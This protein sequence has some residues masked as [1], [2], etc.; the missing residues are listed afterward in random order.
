[1]TEA[2]LDPRERSSIIRDSLGVGVAT[3]AYG[4]GFGAVSVAAGLSVAQTCALSLLVFT[5]ASQFALVGVIATGG[6]P[7]SGALSAM[8][9]GT[10][11]TLYGLRLAP[12]LQWRGW[13]RALAAHV[14]IDESTA[15]SVT[16]ETTP[17]ARLGFLTTGVSVFVLWNV[18]TCAGAVAGNAIGDPRTYGLDAA[19]GAAFLALLWPRL[20]S[21]RNQVVAV[22]AAA[23][24]LGAVPI[25][26]AGVPVLA[27]AAV[28]L[29]AGILTKDQPQEQ[30]P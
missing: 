13:R 17:A 30:Q 3:G 28:A 11:N 4:V 2:T 19:V 1:M 18:A 9:L 26:P 27:A 29:L 5:G 8:L 21:R 23:V 6:A 25:V 16:R 14:L 7:I 10:R 15:M 24:A 20:H 12:M 22:V